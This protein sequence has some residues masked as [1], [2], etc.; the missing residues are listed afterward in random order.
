MDVWRDPLN[1]VVMAVNARPRR[2]KKFIATAKTVRTFLIAQ[3]ID[4]IASSFHL[5]HPLHPLQNPLPN[6]YGLTSPHLRR[7]N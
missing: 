2:E 1:V 5:L 3:T 6:L 7:P 4:F